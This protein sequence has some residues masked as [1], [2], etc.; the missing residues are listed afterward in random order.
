MFERIPRRNKKIFAWTG[1]TV[2]LGMGFSFEA[3]EA[4]Q[5]S[6]HELAARNAALQSHPKEAARLNHAADAY[7]TYTAV[8]GL[9]G[10][11]LLFGTAMSLFMT[12]LVLASED[13]TV[14]FNIYD[15]P[16]TNKRTSLPA[17]RPESISPNPRHAAEYN[18]HADAPAPGVIESRHKQSPE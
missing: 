1:L 5:H 13:G 18:K 11:T 10:L 16:D 4:I 17:S 7:H 12:G 2:C 15:E 14:D 8:D 6:N 3:V 9:V